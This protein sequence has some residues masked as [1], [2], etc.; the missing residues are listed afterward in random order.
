MTLRHR[1]NKKV[2]RSNYKRVRKLGLNHHTARRI[3]DWTKPHVELFINTQNKLR[4]ICWECEQPV[5]PEDLRGL[6]A[7]DGTV[8]GVCKACFNKKFNLG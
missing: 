3:R 6:Q 1:P 8:H 2:R 7:E 5:E 4:D